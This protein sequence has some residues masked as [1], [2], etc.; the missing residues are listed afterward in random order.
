[1]SEG[2]TDNVEA[3]TPQIGYA[4]PQQDIEQN[5]IYAILGYILSLTG[6]PF[7][8]LGLVIPKPESKF[9]KYHANQA[10]LVYVFYMTTNIVLTILSVLSLGICGCLFFITIPVSFIYFVLG[11][12]N[13]AN[14]E[15]KPLPLL[16]N[17][18]LIKDE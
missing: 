5:K 10:L 18:V 1:M 8:I 13:A 2:K 14:G 9:A 6:F 17:T 12:I 3:V 7:F 15:M 4:S 11:T 16:E